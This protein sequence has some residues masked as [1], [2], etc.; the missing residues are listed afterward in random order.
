MKYSTKDAAVGTL[1]EVKGAIKSQA[2]KLI[3]NPTSKPMAS[4]KT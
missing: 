4:S 3:K 1:H 2:G